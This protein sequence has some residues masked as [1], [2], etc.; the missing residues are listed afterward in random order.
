MAS[1][2]VW[3]REAW[4]VRTRWGGNKKKDRRIGTTKADKRQAEQIAKQINAALALGQFEVG[5]KKP[6]PCDVELRCWHANYA[7]TMKHSYET[8][9]EGHIRNH[10]VPFFGGR[11][12]REL[13]EVDLLDYV[14]A[15]LADG[16]APKTIRNTLS[17]LRRVFYLHQRDG[18][19][20][21]N[22]AARIGELMRRVDRRIASSA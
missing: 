18:L 4:W 16:L 10:L 9:T 7:P 21:R 1:K 6:L 22:P 12:L 8:L 19:V 2:V 5:G 3:H 14:R 13:R 17:I 20:E 15:K 11:D